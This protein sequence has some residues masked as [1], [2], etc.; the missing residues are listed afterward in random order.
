MFNLTNYQNSDSNRGERAVL[1]V[2]TMYKTMTVLWPAAMAKDTSFSGLSMSV[3]SWLRM[4]DKDDCCDTVPPKKQS[5]QEAIEESL[6]IVI[7]VLK[8]SS[9]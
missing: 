2:V 8:W 5:R 4:R 9:L 7:K 6:K 1:P 3:D